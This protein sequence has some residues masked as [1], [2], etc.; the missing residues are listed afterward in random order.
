MCA[1]ACVCVR[2]RLSSAAAAA[3]TGGRLH[4]GGKKMLFLAVDASRTVARGAVRRGGTSAGKVLR[5]LE[6]RCDNISR[7]P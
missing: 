2:L 3:A 4:V 1:R 7:Y 6:I 5:Q